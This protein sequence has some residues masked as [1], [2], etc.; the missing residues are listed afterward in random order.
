MCTRGSQH[1][2]QKEMWLVSG[3]QDHRYLSVK[4]E[5]NP[6][7]LLR[8]ASMSPPPPPSNF[9][10]AQLVSMT[11]EGTHVALNIKQQINSNSVI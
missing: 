10:V 7:P 8:R 4:S 6:P 9:Q 2:A 11:E 5:S 1:K 3:L